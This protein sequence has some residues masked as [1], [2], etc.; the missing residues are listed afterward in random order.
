MKNSSKKSI[1]ALSILTLITFS[2]QKDFHKTLIEEHEKLEENHQKMEEAHIKMGHKHSDIQA[3]LALHGHDKTV[4]EKHKNDHDELEAKHA[5]I[6]KK[7]AELVQKHKE[8]EGRHSA[9]SS[10]AEIRK[11]HELMLVEH[12]QI[13]AE[14]EQMV[15]EHKQLTEAHEKEHKS[16]Q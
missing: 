7:H 11:D 8:L 12:K 13:Q 1:L 3:E 5:A 6:L 4:L 16:D 14:H 2:C 10:E 15:L 9:G